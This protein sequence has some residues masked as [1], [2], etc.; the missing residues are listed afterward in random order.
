MVFCQITENSDNSGGIMLV[1]ISTIFEQYEFWIIWGM[2]MIYTMVTIEAFKEVFLFENKNNA[3]KVVVAICLAI[4]SMLLYGGYERFPNDDFLFKC[5]LSQLIVSSVVIRRDPI[6]TF[7]EWIEKPFKWIRER[8]C[9]QLKTRYKRI[10]NLLSDLKYP[11][12]ANQVKQLVQVMIPKLNGKISELHSSITQV[13]ELIEQTDDKTSLEQSKKALEHILNLHK[14][15]LDK[16]HLFLL[17]TEGRLLVV[18]M[19]GGDLDEISA[20]FESLAAEVDDVINIQH[21]TN[22]EMQRAYTLSR[23]IAAQSVLQST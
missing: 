6:G 15:Q 13:Q 21:S 8:T 5:T 14:E 7:F 19:G 12:L 22:K 20:L 9:P 23:S 2:L 4:M 17:N 18:K 16:C 10:K 3:P 1:E 11:R